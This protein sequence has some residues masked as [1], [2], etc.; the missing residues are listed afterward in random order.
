MATDIA[1]NSDSTLMYSQGASWPECDHAPERLDDVRLRRD[2]VGADHL[3]AAE[4]HGL[5]DSRR[6]FSLLEHGRPPA[7]S[8]HEV[9]GRRRRRPRSPRRFS[10]A[11]FSRIAAMTDS[12]D[13]RPVRRRSLRAAPH[14][15]TGARRASS[16]SPS[17]ARCSRCSGLKPAANSPSPRSSNVRARVD[18]DVAVRREPAKDVHLVQQ[19]RVLDDASRRARGPARAGGSAGRRCGRTPRPARPCARSRSSERPAHA[20]PRGMPR[21][22]AV[23]R[24]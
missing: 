21:P 19:R 13:M 9:R 24:R 16:R 8:A 10:P 2:R 1:A 4:R 11:N 12:S 7:F 3:G 15:A 5:G 14:S 18:H 20:G 6:T 17:R 23:R 22:T